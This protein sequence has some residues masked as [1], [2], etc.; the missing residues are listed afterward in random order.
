M[1]NLPFR[2]V[3][4]FGGTLLLLGVTAQCGPPFQ[5]LVVDASPPQDPWMKAIGDLDQDGRPDLVLCGRGG[6]LVWY[7]NPSWTRRT[8]SASTGTPGTA[9]G[10]AIGDVD[11]NGSPDVVL[12]N[13]VWFKNPRPGGSAELGAWARHQ[14][15]ATT[16]HDV[17]LADLDRDGDLDLVKRNQGATGDVIRV[18]RQ[19]PG[20][21]WTER[22]IPVPAGEGLAVADLDAD[23][24]PDIAIAGWWYENDGN[25]ISGAWRPSA[26]TTSYTHPHVVVKVGNVGG[27]SRPDIVLSPSEYAG[28]SHRISWFEAP[29]NARAIWPERVVASGVETV[30]H[31]LVLADFDRNGRTDLALAEMHQGADPDNVRVLLQSSSGTFASTAFSSLGSHILVGADLNADGRVDLFGANHNTGQAA[32]RARAKI[33]L[34]RLP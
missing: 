10:I 18:F 27:S 21:T 5:E 31:A 29:S 15:D 1:K 26:Y 34:N 11:R 6:P 16:A 25:P 19:N 4:L 17:S 20:L 14:I 8:I 23:G 3:G 7:E 9:N 13:G 30:V 12:A 33:W 28:G 24:D 32:D 2:L 22:A